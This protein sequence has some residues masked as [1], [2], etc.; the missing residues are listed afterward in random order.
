M[1]SIGMRVL[2]NIEAQQ[3]FEENTQRAAS[4]QKALEDY[5][6][7]Y[8]KL[9]PLLQ[10]V[11][12]DLQ[13]KIPPKQEPQVKPP[14]TASTTSSSTSNT[15]NTS[16]NNNNTTGAPPSKKAPQRKRTYTKKNQ[17]A[18]PNNVP[19]PATNLQ[20]NARSNAPI[21]PNGNGSGSYQA[22][23]VIGFNSFQPNRESS[24]DAN[25]SENQPILL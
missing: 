1:S 25:G 12:Q 7:R 24:T 2:T 14:S 18:T 9:T 6:E 19:T 5:V 20:Q 22:G 17:A 21:L 11:N 13:L 15:S 8:K 4:L 10:L 3:A 23:S 16:N